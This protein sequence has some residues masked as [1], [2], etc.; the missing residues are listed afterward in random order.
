MLRT[1]RFAACRSHMFHVRA[2]L[3]HRALKK[4][5]PHIYKALALHNAAIFAT[6]EQTRQLLRSTY[7][8]SSP[9]EF[10]C[11]LTG[12]F[13]RDFLSLFRLARQQFSKLLE[14]IDHHPALCSNRTL[15]KKKAPSAHQ[16]LVFLNCFGSHQT[17]SQV[18]LRFKIGLGSVINYVSNC[19]LAI[20]A[21][22]PGQ[23]AWLSPHERQCLK[24]YYQRHFFWNNVVGAVDGSCIPLSFCPSACGGDY[25]D[26]SVITI[27]HLLQ[28]FYLILLFDFRKS[29]Y[30][31]NIQFVV[32]P[33]ARVRYQFGGVPGSTHDS[34][35]I[36]QPS[37][38]IFTTTCIL[39]CILVF[40]CFLASAFRQ[41]R[42]ML[43]SQ[44]FFSPGEHLLADSAYGN[45]N[46]IVSC[47]KRPR[48]N[49]LPYFLLQTPEVERST[50]LQF[51]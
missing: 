31:I 9:N 20:R 12:I 34:R 10:V 25:F 48:Q 32:D 46:Y 1:I 11:C 5:A 29:N 18:E 14:S 39:L 42:M 45:S 35:Y 17:L 13:A 30:S 19:T 27:I 15:Y 24:D 47:F 28:T 23:I 8:P 44:E 38:L 43:R 51:A 49:V 40:G 21:L 36:F 26:R 16:L 41:S 2:C 4:K 33:D 6:C 22:A 50:L 37:F 7:R 3:L